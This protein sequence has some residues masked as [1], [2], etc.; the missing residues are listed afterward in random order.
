MKFIKII[1]CMLLIFGVSAKAEDNKTQSDTE[2]NTRITYDTVNAC[3][4][5]TY[6]WIVM[7]N[8]QLN[9]TSPPMVV[10]RQM[11]VHCFCVLDKIRAQFPIKEYMKYVLSG[12]NLGE[13]FMKKSY[14]CMREYDTMSGIIILPESLD[15]ATKTDN[16]TTEKLEVLPTKP[17]GPEESS[18][19]EQEDQQI[20]LQG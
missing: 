12:I 18:P 5:G 7:A 2:W 4:Q 14:D 15:N 9:R 3:Y 20:I 19:E 16:E 6:Q 17:E 11:V 10:Q 13:L 1:L 8:P